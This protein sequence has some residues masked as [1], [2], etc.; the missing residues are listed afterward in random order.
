MSRAV[1]IQ[2]GMHFVFEGWGFAFSLACGN[3][4]S[5]SGVIKQAG[6]GEGLSLCGRVP[7]PGNMGRDGRGRCGS[8]WR[9]SG[10]FGWWDAGGGSVY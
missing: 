3:D 2:V 1:P 4:G 6:R 8:T 10:C 5:V 7:V 9:C